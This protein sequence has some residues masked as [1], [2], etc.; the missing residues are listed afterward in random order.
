MLALKTT[1]GG[2]TGATGTS[3]LQLVVLVGFGHP[4][5]RLRLGAVRNDIC[6]WV[7]DLV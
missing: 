7:E 1:S 3:E 6:Q 2:R 5:R 4:A